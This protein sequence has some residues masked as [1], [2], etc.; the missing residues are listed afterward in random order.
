MKKI[1]RFFKSVLMFVLNEQ[2]KP[3]NQISFT[4]DEIE[5]NE[6]YQFFNKV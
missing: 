6:L 2:N 3:V 1:S 4:L 5:N